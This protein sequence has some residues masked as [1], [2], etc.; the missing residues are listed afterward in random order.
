[1]VNPPNPEG[2]EYRDIR[3]NF[4]GK[5]I[6]T[7]ILRKKTYFY[8]YNHFGSI[9][10]IVVKKGTKVY[11]DPISKTIFFNPNPVKIQKILNKYFIIIEE[12]KFLMHFPEG[13]KKLPYP[14][15][16]I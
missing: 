16:L 1:L 7:G 6:K 8:F 15:S 12:E 11:A 3:Y 14:L 9:M 5:M 13:T 4:W 2:A 10:T